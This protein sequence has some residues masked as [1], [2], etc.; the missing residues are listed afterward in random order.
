MIDM[1]Y[2]WSEM[3]SPLSIPK[4]RQPSRL[5]VLRRSRRW[6]KGTGEG[7]FSSGGWGRDARTGLSTLMIPQHSRFHSKPGRALT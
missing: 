7:E 5:V 6:K 1:R 3:D 4:R 2:M